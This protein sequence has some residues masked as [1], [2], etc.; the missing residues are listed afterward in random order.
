MKDKKI[1]GIK[2]TDTASRRRRIS[3]NK[4]V[5]KKMHLTRA[6]RENVTRRE[7]GRRYWGENAYKMCE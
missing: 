4:S 5:G 1:K 3:K 6:F 2:A 7:K